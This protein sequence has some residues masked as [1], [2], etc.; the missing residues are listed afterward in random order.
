[1]TAQTFYTLSA[2]GVSVIIDL[3]TGRPVVLHWGADLGSAIDAKSLLSAMQ[4]GLPHSDLDAFQNPGIW[5]ENSRGYLGRPAVQGHR[6]GQDWS[7][8]FDITE[9]SAGENTL[10]VRS[11][12]LAAGLEVTA[13]FELG[14]SG[15]L[16]ISQTIKNLG[17][18]SFSLGE[19]TT[20]LPI[21]DYVSE[22]VDFTGRWVKERQPQRREIQVGTWAREIRE[23]RTGHDYTIVQLAMTKDADYQRG[24]VFSLGLQWSGNTRHLVERQPTGRTTMGA[25]ELLLPGEVILAAGEIYEAPTVVA[26]YSGEGVDGITD[27]HYRWLRSRPT[28]PSNVR[29][30]PLTLNVWEAVY[31][32]HNLEKLEQLA[33]VAQEIGV[34]RFVLDDGWFG[35]RRDDHSGLGDWVVSKDVWPNGLKPLIDVVKSRGM[36]FGLWFEGEMVNP[37]SDLYRAHPEWILHVGDRVPPEG[38]FQQ[39]LDLTHQGAYDHV[40]GQVDAI[41]S[42]YD[43]AYIKWDHNRPLIEAAHLGQAAV[44]EQ[45]KA[46]YRLFDQLKANH[47]GLEI[48]SCSSGGGRIDLGMVEH[49]DRF[50]TSDC[51]DA[52]ER[53]YIQRYTQ[54]AIPPEMLGSHIGPT[55]SHTTHRTHSLSFRA[56]SALFGHAGIEWDV[57]ETT[58]EERAALKS[59]ASYYKANRS[60]LHTGKMIRV[61]QPDDSSFVHGVVSQDK[62]K[63]IFAY[64]TL[65]AIPGMTPTALR[66]E[67]LDPKANYRIKMVQPA[68]SPEYVQRGMPTWI[69]G[70]ELSGAALSK[71]GVRPPILAP[72]N[73]FLVEVQR[74]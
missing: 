46:I 13:N 14:A 8:M 11:A 62:S 4:E 66:L 37:D 53:Q 26:S 41:L 54:F 63:A 58:P 18:T 23:G 22:T 56:I 72:E 36:E 65:R 31:F 12:D 43:I 61:E 19:L 42:E 64:V 6:D 52:L 29:P 16:K 17:T 21:P 15:I 60:L 45:T 10:F 55:H 70:V 25:G 73:G 20:W 2:D 71:I 9:V 33:D 5:R 32:N 68:G 51:N 34:E 7:Q 3:S 38:R 35:S 44:R 24:E 67:G 30:R 69:D 49:A 50:W 57:T 74:V 28:H 1:M 48:E 47:P 40:F 39:V 59:W 27:R